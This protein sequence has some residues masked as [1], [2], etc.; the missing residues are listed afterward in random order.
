MNKLRNQYLSFLQI[1]RKNRKFPKC[2]K[3]VFIIDQDKLE[4]VNLGKFFPMPPS[5]RFFDIVW[6]RYVYRK[7]GCLIEEGSNPDVSK[8][9]LFISSKY[10]LIHCKVLLGVKLN[11]KSVFEKY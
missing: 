2:K 9:K 1:I 8:G 10:F 3:W 7:L 6:E 11:L 4:S 5:V